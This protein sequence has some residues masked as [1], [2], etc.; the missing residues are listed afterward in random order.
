[1]SCTAPLSPGLRREWE[2]HDVLALAVFWGGLAAMAWAWAGYPLLAGLAAATVKHGPQ[3]HPDRDGAGGCP[4]ISV[5]VAVHDEERALPAKLQNC[6]ELDYPATELEV[7]VA[8]DG[9]Q[10]GTVAIAQDF[11][12]RHSNVRLVSSAARCGK[13]SIQNAAAAAAS[14]EV[15]LFTDVDTVLGRDALHIVAAGFRR[16][17]AGCLTGRVMWQSKEGSGR[18]HSENLYWRYEHALWRRETRLGILAWGSGPCLAVRRHLFRPIDPCFGDDVAIPFDVIAQGFSV[19]YEPSLVALEE[20]WEG[21]GSALRARARMTLRGFTGTL[22]RRRVY[23]PWQRPGLFVAVVSH[24]LLRWV[25]PFL[26]LAVLATAVPLAVDS[27]P[28]AQG[29]LVV[30]VGAVMAAVAGGLA[31]RYGVRVPFVNAAYD[32]AL[33]NI[34]MLVGVAKGAAGQ[35][36]LAYGGDQAELSHRP[37]GQDGLWATAPAYGR[38]PRRLRVTDAS[39]TSSRT[40]RTPG[41]SR[42]SLSAAPRSGA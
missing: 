18:A 21:D 3:D 1:M 31:A 19:I 28:A 26:F 34:G 13:S 16:P 9:S 17:S 41:Q 8:S 30:Q 33:E 36:Q 7:L 5:V 6:L 22:A 42:C 24:K 29:I 14:G 39:G 38:R 10:D 32:L 23:S 40:S 35:R 12:A 4:S 15:L 2:A 11:A 37:G 20:S 27:Y 25:T